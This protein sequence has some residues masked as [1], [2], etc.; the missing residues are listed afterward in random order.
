MSTDTDARLDAIAK[1]ARV[2]D[3]PLPFIPPCNSISA[4]TV[5]A[6]DS[7]LHEPKL[8][9]YRLQVIKEGRRMRLYS[10]RGN[11]WTDRL[12]ELADALAGIPC[13]FAITPSCASRAPAALPT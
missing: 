12:R 1:T 5:P 7:W 9:G 13:R 4:M 6:G 10:R 2:D 11:E 8:D 3:V